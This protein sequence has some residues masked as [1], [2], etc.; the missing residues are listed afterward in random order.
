MK[1]HLLHG[2]LDLRSSQSE[3]LES[4]NDRPIESSIRSRRTIRGRKLGLRI[5]RRSSG[6]AVKHA[7]TLQDLM[8]ILLLMKE[9]AIRTAHHLDSE[10]V[11]QRTLVLDGELSAKTSRQ[12][13]EEPS[14][15]PSYLPLPSMGPTQAIFSP[16]QSP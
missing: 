3:V 9:E 12:L 14:L 6:L 7:G 15:P 2:I 5:N 1:T 4:I 16:S 11:V 10:E 13:T 8:S